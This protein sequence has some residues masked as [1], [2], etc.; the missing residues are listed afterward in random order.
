MSQNSANNIIVKAAIPTAI[1]GVVTCAAAIAAK[2][3]AGLIGAIFGAAIVVIF[4]TIGQV[5]LNRVIKSNPTMAMTVAMTMYLVKI[6]VLFGL[7]LIFKNT[8]AFDTK[9]FALSVLVCTLT[10]TIAEV[11]AF[12]TQKVLYVEPGS[13]PNY[14]PSDDRPPF[15]G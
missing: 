6:A 11:W 2:G 3:S 9:V 15:N 12:G 8:S 5:V 7:L 10:W 14:T 13:G 4:F 1:V